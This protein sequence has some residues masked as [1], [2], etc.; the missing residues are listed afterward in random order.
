MHQFCGYQQGQQADACASGDP[1]VGSGDRPTRL[2]GR[3]KDQQAKEHGSCRPENQAFEE[4]ACFQPDR[5]E[6]SAVVELITSAARA[7]SMISSVLAGST[8]RQLIVNCSARSRSSACQASAVVSGGVTAA[9]SA[10]SKISRR[11]W[12]KTIPSCLTRSR[13][14]TNLLKLPPKRSSS[15]AHQIDCVCTS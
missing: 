7:C 6:P 5:T 4:S 2:Q 14:C 1:V 3:G 11:K 13:D 8:A 12:R 15:P 10:Q 9:S